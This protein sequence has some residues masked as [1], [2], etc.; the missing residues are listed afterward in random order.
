LKIFL[1]RSRHG[2]VE[3][4]PFAFETPQSSNVE[5]KRRKISP[6]DVTHVS[7]TPES[8]FK[9][10][11]VPKGPSPTQKQQRTSPTDRQSGETV[12]ISKTDI[13]HISQSENYQLEDHSESPVIG[14]KRKATSPK[15]DITHISQSQESQRE[16]KPKGSSISSPGGTKLRL[17]RSN[18][19]V[20]HISQ[21]QESQHEEKPKG[22]SMSSPGGKKLRLTRS[23]ADVTHISQSQESQREEKPKGSSMSSPGGKK[24][25][26]TRSNANVTHVSQSQLSQKEEHSPREKPNEKNP[27]ETTHTPR[28][29]KS[30]VK[31]SGTALNNNQRPKRNASEEEDTVIPESQTSPIQVKVK[32]TPSPEISFTS[33]RRKISSPDL[34]HVS[35]TERSVNVEPQRPSSVSSPRTGQ[36]NLDDS[37]STCV[38][39]IASTGFS[40]HRTS[41]QNLSSIKSSVSPPGSGWMSKK[42]FSMKKE[43]SEMNQS[44]NR[45]NIDG[46]VEDLGEP[47]SG[48]G[49]Q[50]SQ[51]FSSNQEQQKVGSLPILASF[52]FDAHYR[53]H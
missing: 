17:T 52:R 51:G 21:S 10:P 31:Q 11:G 16:E 39:N 28:S 27:R 42:S 43:K 32:E 6:T 12:S 41:V 35:D 15:N 14:Q 30:Q 46:A 38:E 7:Q 47:S 1:F 33:K 8:E 19:D 37:T 20:T 36:V 34:T 4:Q 48:R 2:S 22:S 53:Y 3:S 24:L 40:D 44:E 25:R 45:T 26:L 49:F 13:T 29:Q 50:E 9:T 18:A 5:S 23:N